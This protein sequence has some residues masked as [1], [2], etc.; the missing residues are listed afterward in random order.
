MKESKKK[1]KSNNKALDKLCKKIT[2][3]TVA[4]VVSLEDYGWVDC[5]FMV[6]AYIESDQCTSKEYALALK[7]L[8]IF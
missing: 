5:E 8:G 6:G 2:G 3:K 1:K 7:L 4:E